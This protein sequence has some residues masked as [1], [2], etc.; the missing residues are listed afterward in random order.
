MYQAVCTWKDSF[1]L[2]QTNVVQQ[3]NE[4]RDKFRDIILIASHS[5]IP[6][7]SAYTLGRIN[8]DCW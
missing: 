7:G 2:L 8:R 5:F 4:K 1:T 6:D 3:R